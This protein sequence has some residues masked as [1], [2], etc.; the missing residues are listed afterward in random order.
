M[1]HPQP[2]KFKVEREQERTEL[3][4]E[5]EWPLGLIHLGMS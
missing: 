3:D 1:A 2:H 5:K 4:P